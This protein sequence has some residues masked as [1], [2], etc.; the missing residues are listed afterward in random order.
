MNT[1]YKYTDV[2]KVLGDSI[3]PDGTVIKKL[4]IYNGKICLES[5]NKAYETLVLNEEDISIVGRVCG[6]ITKV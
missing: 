3:E 1:N 2:L 4:Y 5:N 6:V